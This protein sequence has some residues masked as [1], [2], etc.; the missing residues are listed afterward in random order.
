MTRFKV[1]GAIALAVVMLGCES[2]VSTAPSGDVPQT[3]GGF[4]LLGFAGLAVTASSEENSFHGVGTV[5]DGNLQTA[6]APA[7]TDTAPTLTFDL[8]GERAVDAFSIKLSPQGTTVAVEVWTGAG[9]ERIA[10]GLTPT[11]ATFQT[12][13]LPDRTTTRVRLVFGGVPASELLVCEVAINGTTTTPSPSPRP[14]VVPSVVPSPTPST[15]ACTCKV[16]GGGFVYLPPGTGRNDKATFGLV[17]LTN[18]GRGVTGNLTVV[19]HQ[20]KERYS[21]R[22]TGIDCSRGTTVTFTGTLRKSGAPF[23]A[24][25]TDNGEPGVNDV[26]SF[27]TT[28]FQ[29]SG[30]LGGGTQGGGNIQVHKPT[31]D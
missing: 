5:L 16:T 6:W 22:V 7:Y 15:P 24:T 4:R 18:P 14:S 20:T 10:S 13:D 23:T 8:G 9:W 30:V 11:A 25:V 31:C 21:G 27:S 17:A 19:D 26:F 28:G 2:V 3:T 1:A 12:F 29:A